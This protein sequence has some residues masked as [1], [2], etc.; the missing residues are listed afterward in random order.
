MSYENHY[1][2]AEEHVIGSGMINYHRYLPY[3]CIKPE[4][5]VTEASYKINDIYEFCKT[6][7]KIGFL[8]ES[9]LKSN[10]GLWITSADNTFAE[11]LSYHVY[12]SLDYGNLRD[13]KFEALYGALGT[14]EP[15]KMTELRQSDLDFGLE[16]VSIDTSGN[17]VK[18]VTLF[19]PNSNVLDYFDLPEIDK[20]KEFVAVSFAEFEEGK[21]DATTSFKSPIRIQFDAVDDTVSIELVSP[22]FLSELY[23]AGGSTET[24]LNRKN[25]Y[26]QRMQDAGLLTSEEVEYCRTHSPSHQ[27]FSVKFKWRGGELVD[28]KLYTFVVL[29]FERIA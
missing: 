29:D 15:A 7:A 19:R 16:G 25:L 21:V 23:A 12:H 6:R 28:K 27:Q 5:L 13:D 10:T 22:F 18:Y 14:Q 24:Y 17:V 4:L 8:P 3:D 2:G 9:I 26:F 1:I 20:V 11:D